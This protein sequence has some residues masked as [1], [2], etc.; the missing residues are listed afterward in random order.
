MTYGG[1]SPRGTHQSEP[2]FA[3]QRYGQSDQQRREQLDRQAETIRQSR[4]FVMGNWKSFKTITETRAFIEAFQACYSRTSHAKLAGDIVLFPSFV[5]LPIMGAVCKQI[6]SPLSFGS[7]TVSAWTAGAHTGEVTANMIS[8][9]GARYVLIGHSERRKDQN[10][11]GEITQEKIRRCLEAKLIPV[12]C[13]GESLEE[14]RSQRTDHVL[15]QQ[16]FDAID[17]LEWADRL[18]PI[19]IAYEPVWAIGT[20]LVPTEDQ[21]RDTAQTVRRVL[22]K[23][24]SR[25]QGES[26]QHANSI[27]ILYG[28]SVKRGNAGKIMGLSC[29]QGLLVGGA[30]LDP[31]HLSDI[32]T[33][34]IGQ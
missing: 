18:E 27:P 6:G 3:G 12:L 25:P 34:A 5:S 28:G 32:V 14:R 15:R 17:G 4:H 23:L 22:Q 33:A 7:Q 8:D 13:I 31:E 21:L 10:E 20:G 11:N 19:V 9:V 26:C 2:A 24:F 1:I 29:F 16:L 30:S